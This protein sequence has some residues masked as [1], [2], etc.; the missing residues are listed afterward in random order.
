MA[1]L[2]TCTST[3]RPASPA[4]GDMLYET[5]TG[6]T[7]VCSNASGPVFKVYNSTSSPYNL[8][9]TNTTSVRP[10]FHFDAALWNGAD[11]TGNPSNAT[12]LDENYTW[13]D[14]AHGLVTVGQST[15]SSQPIYYTTGENSKPYVA[16]DGGDSLE[17]ALPPMSHGAFTLF[18]VGKTDS[19]QRMS[20]VGRSISNGLTYGTQTVYFSYGGGGYTETDYLYYNSTGHTSGPH[21]SVGGSTSYAVTRCFLVI[22]DSSD[23][24]SI[25]IDGDNTV[26]DGSTWGPA[27]TNEKCL[28]T[29]LMKG[30]AYTVTGEIYETAVWDSD[31]SSADRNEIGDYVIAKYGLSFDDF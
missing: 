30:G 18:G 8:D 14:R 2:D 16:G 20:F 3:T 27:T 10:L 6:R 17:I 24:T 15:A 26:S 13:T 31:L 11:A 7:I 1:T 22:R 12:T 23:N 19:S 28:W 9:A 21:P 5:D 4:L 29:S 25:W